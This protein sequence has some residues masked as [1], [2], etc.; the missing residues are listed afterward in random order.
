VQER[1]EAFGCARIG[2]R[3]QGRHGRAAHLRVFVP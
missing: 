1:G 3:A 2:E